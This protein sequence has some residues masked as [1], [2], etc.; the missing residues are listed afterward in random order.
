MGVKPEQ[1]IAFEDSPNGALA[2]KRAGMYCVI[3]PNFV[4][5]TLPFHPIDV[6]LQSMAETAL[7]Q[8]LDKIASS[9]ET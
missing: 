3:V 2:A 1:A 7:E 5:E 6:R 4:I 8:L 9:S